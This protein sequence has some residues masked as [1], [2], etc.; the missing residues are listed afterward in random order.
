MPNEEMTVELS[1]I[2]STSNASI[3]NNAGRV[4]KL[5]CQYDPDFQEIRISHAT[6]ESIHLNKSITCKERIQIITMSVLC[7]NML[8]YPMS[9]IWIFTLEMLFLHYILHASCP[10]LVLW[11]VLQRST[12]KT[13][14]RPLHSWF[15]SLMPEFW[16][17]TNICMGPLML[18]VH[19]GMVTSKNFLK[20]LAPQKF[21]LQNY[22]DQLKS[23]SM[24]VTN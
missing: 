14:P 10:L 18:M 6:L 21:K 17:I 1:W 9:K 22:F 24:W 16:Y 23:M 2:N 8:Y 7:F 19:G 3:Y 15:I 20:L 12:K 5:T 11:I 4:V 13:I